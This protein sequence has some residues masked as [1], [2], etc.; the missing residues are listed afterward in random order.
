M[1]STRSRLTALGHYEAHESEFVRIGRVASRGFMIGAAIFS[2][3]TLQHENAFYRYLVLYILSISTVI[4]IA[5]N[6]EAVRRHFFLALVTIAMPSIVMVPYSEGSVQ[7][8]LGRLPILIMSM[9]LFVEF[10]EEY[11]R[12]FTPNTRH[13]GRAP[14]PRLLQLDADSEAEGEPVPL[15]PGRHDELLAHMNGGERDQYRAP[16]QVSS[17]ISL[18][19][20]GSGRLP[21]SCDTRIRA[22]W[23]DA[24]VEGHERRR[25]NEEREDQAD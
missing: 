25:E 19:T 9:S 13:W 14:D 23:C 12:R 22:F 1:T 6:W 11:S 10:F 2:P 3:A 21:S 24:L 16:S 7:L 4:H 20:V 5:F 18:S 17:E 8:L 15:T